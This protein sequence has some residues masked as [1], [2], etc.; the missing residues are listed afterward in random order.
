MHPLL[1]QIFLLDVLLS[2]ENLN[3]EDSKYY[4]VDILLFSIVIQIKISQLNQWEISKS[5]PP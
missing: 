4:L 2:Q 3:Q 1:V 5:I